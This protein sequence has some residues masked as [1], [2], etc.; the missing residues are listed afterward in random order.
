[1]FDKK[2]YLSLICAMG[3]GQVVG[4]I[5]NIQGPIERE[6]LRKDSMVIN[7]PNL[8]PLI[9]DL[10]NSRDDLND[11]TGYANEYEKALEKNISDHIDATNKNISTYT[12][13]AKNLKNNSE[14]FK[15]MVSEKIKN[16]D[17]DIDSMKALQ[18]QIKGDFPVLDGAIQKWDDSLEGWFTAVKK[19]DIAEAITTLNKTISEIYKKHQ[20]IK[21]FSKSIADTVALFDQAIEADAA[22]LVAQSAKAAAAEAKA[23]EEAARQAAEEE[24]TAQA[25]KAL[26]KAEADAIAAQALADKKAAAA[27]RIQAIY[28]KS[29][30]DQ[31]NK[32]AQ[33][34]IEKIAKLRNLV[35]AKVTAID[36]LNNEIQG[37]TSK[38]SA[39]F[40]S[41]VSSRVMPMV[42]T[43]AQEFDGIITKANNIS[44][45]LVALEESLNKA[46]TSLVEHKLSAGKKALKVDANMQEISQQLQMQLR[47]AS[48]LL[49]LAQEHQEKLF[50][51]HSEL[52]ASEIGAQ[53]LEPKVER[54]LTLVR[55]VKIEQGQQKKLS[56]LASRA[57]SIKK[58]EVV[59]R[60]LDLCRAVKLA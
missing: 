51:L 45:R 6:D 22:E 34:V 12:S 9:V 27:A 13:K 15:N 58:Q 8:E 50:D 3:V 54:V 44:E 52:Q 36:T 28:R 24:K 31:L 37:N 43:T 4:M 11:M 20:E 55:A 30:A 56:E 10:D 16:F 33:G 14:N 5:T 1:M 41:D 17:K 26:Q 32:N 59:A 53:L 60:L 25:Q 47:L 57:R 23:K 38:Y 42:V 7:R 46:Y 48:R 49:R 39:E 19:A 40:V 35:Q 29:K 18:T 2:L 21:A